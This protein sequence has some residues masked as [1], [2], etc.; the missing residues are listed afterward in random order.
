MKKFGGYLLTWIAL[1][2]CDGAP[3]KDDPVEA[4]NSGIECAL[5]GAKLFER[6]CTVEEMSGDDGAVLLVGRANVGYRRLQIATD[7]RGD[8]KSG[9]SGKSVSVRVD[10]GGRRLI[11]KNNTNT[12]PHT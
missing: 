5:E 2:G 7:G 3:R 4:E 8:R 12:L 10:L 11:T 6:T 1:A 9:G